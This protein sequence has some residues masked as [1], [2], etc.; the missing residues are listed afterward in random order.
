MFNNAGINKVFL[1][2]HIG[3]TPRLHVQ[4]DGQSFHCFPLVTTEYIKKDGQNTEHVEWHQIKVATTAN[5]DGIAE[6]DKGQLIYL[7]GKV[8][9]RSFVD[10]IG[11]KRYKA[12]IQAISFKILSTQS[13]QVPVYQ[14]L[15][16]AV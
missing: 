2:G 5:L 6:L 3:K 9:T 14:P 15:V 10:E 11:I 1:V 12:E 4:P 13:V 8:K 16:Q 7:E